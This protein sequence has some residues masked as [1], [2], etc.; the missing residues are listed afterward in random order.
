M[1]NLTFGGHV[2]TCLKKYSQLHIVRWQQKK[3]ILKVEKWIA[4]LNN[5]IKKLYEGNTSGRIPDKHFNRLLVKYDTEQ[6][7][8]GARGGGTEREH[9]RPSRELF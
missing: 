8:I 1:E 5:L 4:E 6:S 2:L 3:R 7:R 9:H